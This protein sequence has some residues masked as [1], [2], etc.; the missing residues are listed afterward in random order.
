MVPLESNPEDGQ[1]TGVFPYT[2]PAAVLK[3]V[4]SEPSFRIV[5]NLPIGLLAKF[6]SFKKKVWGIIKGSLLEPKYSFQYPIPCLER[7][8]C[9]DP[10]DVKDV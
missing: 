1:V 2:F 10:A 8:S 9:A 3:Y 6:P 5:L 7:S 4:I